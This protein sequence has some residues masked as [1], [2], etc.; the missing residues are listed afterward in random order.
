[1]IIQSRYNA[2]QSVGVFDKYFLSIGRAGS[3]DEPPS[4]YNRA[5]AKTALPQPMAL[6]VLTS[7]RVD[8]LQ[9]R[10]AGHLAAT[11]LADPLAREVIVVPTYAMGRWLNLRI[12]QQQ[13]IAANLEYLQ[14]AEWLWGLAARLGDGCSERADPFALETL[15]WRVFDLLGQRRRPRGFAPLAAYLA[16]DEDGIKRWQLAQRVAGLFDRYQLYRPHWIEAWARG[17]DDHW[18]A[19]LWRELLADSDSRD[20][21]A[22]I[23]AAIEA[24]ETGAAG[25]ALAAR[26][27]L[28]APSSL[29]PLAIEFVHALARATDV[30]LYLHSPTDQYWADLVSEKQRARRRLE[31]PSQTAYF[32]TRNGLLTSWGRQG[33]A[34]QDLLLDLGPVTESE[35]DASLP[36]AD[37]SMLAALQASLFRLAEAP[38]SGAVDESL[39]VHVCHSPLRECQV[40]HDQLAALLD[41]HPDLGCE[42][43]LVMVPEISR[44]APY[45]EAVFQVDADSQR[46]YLPWN[47]SD[48]SVSNGHP[49]AGAFLQL[50]DLPRSRFARSEILALLDC[51]ELREHFEIGA[52]MR[53]TVR[54]LLERARVYW[55]VDAAQR[56]ALGLPAIAQNTWQQGWDRMFAGFAMT[57]EAH[58]QGIAPLAALGTDEGVA[59]A[60]LR[61]LFDRLVAWRDELARGTTAADW[62]RRLHRLLDDFFVPA[63]P[64]DDLRNPL[65]DA[66]DALAEAGD[67]VLSPALVRYWLAQ[68]LATTPRPGRLYSGGITFCGLQPLRNIP[69]PVICVLGLDDGAFPRADRPLEFDL[70]RRDWR[71]GDPRRGDE[72]RYLM[73]ETLLCARRHLYFSYCGRSLRDDSERQPS[74][75]LRELLDYVDRNFEPAAGDARASLSITREHPMQPFAAPNFAPPAR[76][77]DGYWHDTAQRL[78]AAVSPAPS[79]AAWPAQ[80]LDADAVPSE[81]DADGLCR[82]FAHPVRYFF[83]QRLGIWLPDEPPAEDEEC[84]VLSALQ[85]WDLGGRVSRDWMA[86]GEIAP[87]AYRAEGLLP[88]GRAADWAWDGLLDEFGELFETLAPYRDRRTEVRQIDCRIDD[89][90][91]LRGE[92]AGCIDGSGL[93]RYTASRSLR[94]RALST[95]WL[96]H[97]LLCAGGRLAPGEQSRLILRDGAG[98]S[99]A[100]LERDA[101]QALLADLVGI[102][103]AGQ[104]CPLPLFAETS[105]AWARGGDPEQARKKAAAAWYTG[106]YSGALP[107][108]VEDRYIRLALPPGLDDPLAEPRFQSLAERVYGVALAHDANRG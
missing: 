43:I 56:E 2:M 23:R 8:I 36:P 93:L 108:E 65:R 41:R 101:A 61:S 107:G 1:M 12:A 45:I 25:A 54:D 104:S 67:A 37:G 27:S 72:D 91:R 100:P 32:E 40:L 38:P 29:A 47:L 5:P 14:P 39:A 84:F 95:L 77:Y 33:Q 13:G 79:A 69:F 30:R 11:P 17:D 74:V 102:Y 64:V 75:L 88:H 81:I 62:Q 80:A 35:I 106:E 96:E 57:G 66:I 6:T 82:F 86:G 73:L 83:Q 28:F 60:R 44:Y 51:D 4:A 15:A 97:L 20:R 34:M 48:V 21:V 68:R 71:P 3:C 46:P 63:P 18:Q 87:D 103:R 22:V 26:I 52:A 55:G 49:Q 78:A 53:D 76:A 89:G 50:L 90:M 24:L 31:N 70:M 94:G 105:L 7:N 58:W 59:L 19:R 10:L 99:F 92:I 85:L 16:D 9:A 42:D 98:P